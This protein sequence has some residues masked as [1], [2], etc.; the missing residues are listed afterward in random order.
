M[1]T[2]P[3]APPVYPGTYWQL[4][5]RGA[6][7][8]P[9]H[10]LLADDHGRS[11]TASEL[12]TAAEGFAATLHA[13][14][15]GAGTVVSWQ[16]PSVLETMVVLCAL[17]RLGAAQNP[18]VP[19]MR[20]REVRFITRQVGTELFLVP[21]TWG[22]FGF[23]DLARTLADESGFDVML[24][25]LGSDPAAAGPD[26]KDGSLR[27]ELGDPATLPP[28]PE[29]DATAVRWLYHTSGTTAE[30]KGIRHSDATLMA[31]STGMIAV[32]GARDDDVNPGAFPVSHIGG[33]LSLGASF[34]TG[35]RIVLFETFDPATFGE[36]A[37]THDPTILGSAVP[38]FLVLLDAQRRHG[39]E[40]LFP[41]LRICSAGGAPLPPEIC[42]EV[43]EVLGVAG[44][45]NGWGLTE[46]P[47]ATF[48]SPDAPHDVLDTTVGTV[49]PGVS[50]RVIGFDEQEVEPGEEGELRL[51][52]PQ[53]MLGYVDARLDADAFDDDGW[54][55]SGDL[56]V[57][58]TDGNVRITGRLKDIII[59]NAENIS[60]LEVEDALFQHAAVHDVAV[61][62][63]PDARS[64]ERVCAVVVPEPGRE[65]PTLEALAEHCRAL[66]LAAQK[67]P[68]R[69][70]VVDGLPRTP[71][72]KVRKED[73]RK[74]Y[75]AP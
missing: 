55:R 44:V 27:L 54:F 31:G 74:R 37:A 57:V 66:G 26:R 29:A 73:L 67:W 18:I 40:P 43:R 32:L 53:C 49:V 34:V 42:R 30:P 9:D 1:L 39:A 64:G 7:E 62:G 56:G 33:A 68:E 25:D 17:A 20:E 22:G 8:R 38:F 60:A 75:G 70:E 14:G 11:L 12:A 19:I 58:D 28:P 35:M 59:R 2:S 24:L 63:L 36:R 61:I 4:V 10:V 5:E 41:R 13:R 47:V 16:L 6:R 46:F 23:G 50:L 65:V 48:A 51:K 72:G 69:V 3:L 52:G 15:V 45:A 21:E 71:M